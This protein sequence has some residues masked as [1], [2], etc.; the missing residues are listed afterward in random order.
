[1]LKTSAESGEFMSAS[2]VEFVDEF[3]G[4]IVETF[5]VWRTDNGG[6]SWREIYSVLNPKT[7]G[8][9]K[10]AFFVNNDVQWVATSKGQLFQT[11][12]GGVSWDPVS[13]A[14]NVSIT[15]VFF[16]GERKGWALGFSGLPSY[17]KVYRTESGGKTWESLPPLEANLLITSIVFLNEREGWAAGRIWT[18]DPKTSGGALLHTI[19]GGES[20]TEVQHLEQAEPFFARV[21]FPNAEHGWLVG[22]DSLYRTQNSGKTWQRVLS[23]LPTG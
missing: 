18:G 13:I 20:W 2:Q 9:P 16:V 17:T 5:R 6:I 1:M 4:W 3:D 12:N 7:D 23:L 19:N 22:R 11:R 8:Q 14:K 21:Y 10:A 15:D